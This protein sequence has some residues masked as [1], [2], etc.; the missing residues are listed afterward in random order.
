[1]SALLATPGAVRSPA[2]GRTL[3]GQLGKV[4]HL[5]ATANGKHKA[6]KLR[7][8]RAALQAF[9]NKVRKSE[10]RKLDTAI[11]AAVTDTAQIALQQIGTI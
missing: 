6:S 9:M 4:G 2:L 7:K 11:G 8:A 10:G 1:M 5:V 3:K